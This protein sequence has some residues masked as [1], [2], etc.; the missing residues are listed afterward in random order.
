MTE[1]NSLKREFFSLKKQPAG[2][3]I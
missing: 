1:V 2:K 3:S